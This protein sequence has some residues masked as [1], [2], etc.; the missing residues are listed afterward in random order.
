LFFIWLIKA[1]QVLVLVYLFK[2]KKKGGSDRVTSL[3]GRDYS[4]ILSIFYFQMFFIVGLESKIF[5]LQTTH[6]KVFYFFGQTIKQG[7]VWL[8][9]FL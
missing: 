3:T 8:R 4:S 9:F 5:I 6:T 2:L 1:R 7:I